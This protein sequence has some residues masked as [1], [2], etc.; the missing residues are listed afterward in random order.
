MHE[1][2]LFQPRIKLRVALCDFLEHFDLLFG[3]G[4]RCF[5]RF[6]LFRGLP[7][8]NPFLDE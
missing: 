5:G 8:I 2:H 3:L 1:A 6:P 7:S 4:G